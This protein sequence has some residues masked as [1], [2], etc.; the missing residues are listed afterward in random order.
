MLKAAIDGRRRVVWMG[1]RVSVWP[2]TASLAT[3]VA[4]A[5]CR[6]REEETYNGRRE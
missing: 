3:Y 1:R 2:F 4:I 5:D 6:G